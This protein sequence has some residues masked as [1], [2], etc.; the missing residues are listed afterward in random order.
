MTAHMKRVVTAF[1]A[2][3]LLTGIIWFGPFWVLTIVVLVVALRG[4]YEF[5]AM[6]G[7]RVTKTIMFITYVLTVLLF[8]SLLYKGLFFMAIL[9]LFVMFPLA[10]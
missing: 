9:P 6:L 1:I 7:P 5:Y 8:C 4:L 10:F 3:P 2:V